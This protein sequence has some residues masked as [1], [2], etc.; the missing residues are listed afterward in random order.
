M[1]STMDLSCVSW[2]LKLRILWEYSKTTGCWEWW[3]L[4]QLH[5]IC[6]S[7]T[8]LIPLVAE[9]ALS[10]LEMQRRWFSCTFSTGSTFPQLPVCR[11]KLDKL[12]SFEAL[13]LYYHSSYSCGAKAYKDPTSRY[14]FIT[15]T[16]PRCLEIFF[17]CCFVGPI[18]LRLGVLA[19]SS[20]RR[21][22]TYP[23]FQALLVGIQ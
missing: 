2:I 18:S 20:C 8:H 11:V 13:I 7:K 4:A 14:P 9:G 3:P 21:L 1:K 23:T 16:L 15:F 12:D 19:F 10:A 17:Q 22:A 6:P 5:G